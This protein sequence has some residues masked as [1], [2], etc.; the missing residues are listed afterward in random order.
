MVML[1]PMIKEKVNWTVQLTR[2]V[3]LYKKVDGVTID[4][5]FCPTLANAFQ[6]HFKKNWSQDYPSGFKP[7][8]YRRYIGDILALFTSPKH[9]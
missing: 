4:L 6:V 9:L 3:V 1:N 5:R 2:T 7:H 8:Y